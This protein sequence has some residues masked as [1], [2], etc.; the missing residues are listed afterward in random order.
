VMEL[1][2]GGNLIGRLKNSRHKGDENFVATLVEKVLSALNYCHA[3]GVA[4]RDIKLENIMYEDDS[5]NAEPKLIDFGFA[6]KTSD[7]M[8]YR[9]GTPS[10]MA[11]ELCVRGAEI[12]Y[13]EKVDVWALGV[14]TFLMLSGKRPFDHTDSREKKRRIREE[15]LKFPS[16]QFDQISRECQD[17]LLSTMRKS[18]ADRMSAETALQHPWIRHRSRVHVG[19]DAATELH[20]HQEIVAALEAYS[21][22]DNLAKLAMQVIAFSAPPGK[23]E[24]LRALFHKMD[25]DGSGTISLDEFRKAM[26]QHP[27]IPKER[28][29][30]MF[31]EMDLDASDEI[32]YT[33][34][35]AATLATVNARDGQG[36]LEGPSLLSAFQVLD[37]DHDGFIDAKDLECAFEG[38]LSNAAAQSILGHCSSEEDSIIRV[39]FDTFKKIILPMVDGEKSGDTELFLQELNARASHASPSKHGDGKEGEGGKFPK[40][41]AAPAAAPANGTQ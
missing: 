3:H 1:C 29:E 9:L 15:P 2:A 10:Y 30:E 13:D 11:P 34:F 27:E 26:S 33:E 28:I 17:F 16:P 12:K 32:D 14:T 21:H 5:E 31:F 38:A 41:H 35:L 36:L 24:E 40:E 19:S 6:T 25:E 7:G 37:A 20:D 39:N 8:W 4:H 18:P 22:S 23:F